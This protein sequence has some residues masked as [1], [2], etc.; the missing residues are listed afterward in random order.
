MF[1]NRN[2]TGH[3]PTINNSPIRNRNYYLKEGISKYRI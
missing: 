1:K 3:L 2:I